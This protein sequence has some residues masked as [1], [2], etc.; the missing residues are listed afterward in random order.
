MNWWQGFFDEEYARY[1]LPLE[2]EEQSLQIA[3]LLELHPGQRVFDQCCG[4][5]RFSLGL[6]QQG[7][8]PI[9]VDACAEYVE[10][11]RTACPEGQFFCADATA[12][13]TELPC[14]GGF[15]VYSSFGYSADDRFNLEMLKQA[16]A[17]LLPQ[18]LFL[19]ETINFAN[20]LVNFQPLMVTQLEEGLQLERRSRL[21][22]SQGMLRQEWT[23]TRPD[24][25]SRRHSTCT[26][27]LLPRELGEMLQAAGL[28]PER[29]LGNLAGD[30]FAQ[31]NPRLVWLAR[32]R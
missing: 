20:V 21:D 15:N 9:G 19:L 6:A 8:V 23:L 24:Q 22:W 28:E 1:F 29:L 5:G 27:M 18:G 10:A 2:V 3:R 32:R 14:H 17:S 7:L 11:A 4:Q 13:R 26:R 30:E 25:T 12:F 31:D 16:C